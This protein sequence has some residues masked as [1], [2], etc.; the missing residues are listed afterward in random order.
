L[1]C[2]GLL[3]HSAAMRGTAAWQRLMSGRCMR[4]YQALIAVFLA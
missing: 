2:R 3:T 1:A 4:Q